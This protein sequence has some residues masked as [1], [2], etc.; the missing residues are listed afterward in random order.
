MNWG[1]LKGKYVK[2]IGDT[3][4]ITRNTTPKPSFRNHLVVSADLAPKKLPQLLEVPFKHCGY[5]SPRHPRSPQRLTKVAKPQGLDATVTGLG[6]MSLYY[7]VYAFES[8]SSRHS[9][10]VRSR[11]SERCSAG[12][13]NKLFLRSTPFL[14]R[15][16]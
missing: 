8:S 1:F 4:E 12:P 11:R 3:T 14:A 5:S 6:E 9:T 7:W 16:V 13:A 2:I 15:G 10:A